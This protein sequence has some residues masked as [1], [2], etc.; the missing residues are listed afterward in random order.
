VHA[1]D[2]HD[3]V[4]DGN[5]NQSFAHLIFAVPVEFHGVLSFLF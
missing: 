5:V 4:F 3:L 1:V 2:V